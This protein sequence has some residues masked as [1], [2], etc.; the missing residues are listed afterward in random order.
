MA[1]RQ[2]T[3][4]NDSSDDSDAPEAVSFGASEKTARGEREVVQRFAAA[5]KL[6]AKE[7]NR[8]RDAALKARAENAK[9]ASGRAAKRPRVAE[10]DEEDEEDDEEDSDW[11]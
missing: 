1:R 8:A 5:E 3:T 10:E 11:E 2:K 9:A 7:K 6:K 4:A